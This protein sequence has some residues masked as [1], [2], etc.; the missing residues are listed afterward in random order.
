MGVTVG[1]CSVE[2]KPSGPVHD[3]AVAPLELAFN[4]AVPS[5]QIAPLLVGAADGAGLTVNVVVY[6]DD[7]LHPLPGL[8]N[9][10]E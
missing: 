10:K 9:V 8:L 5:A 3:Q 4:D 2:V 6:V 7:A 1:F